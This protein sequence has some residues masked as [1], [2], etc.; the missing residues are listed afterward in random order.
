VAFQD[1]TSSRDDA[2]REPPARGVRSP[3]RANDQAIL[4]PKIA[5][6]TIAWEASTVAPRTS[7]GRT[8]SPARYVLAQ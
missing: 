1:E 6:R 8:R 3:V 2:F 5:A 7:S 4:S